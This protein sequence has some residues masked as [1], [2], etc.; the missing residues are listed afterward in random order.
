MSV[1]KSR[2][3]KSPAKFVQLAD[4]IYVEVYNFMMRLSNRQQRL[5]AP[6]TTRLALKALDEAE[7]GNSIMVKDENTYNVRTTHLLE[8]LAAMNAVDV[9]MTHIWKILMQN[10]QG[11]FTKSDGSTKSPSEAIVILDDMANSLGEKIDMFY[12]YVNKLIENEREKYQY[13]VND[14]ANKNKTF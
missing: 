14:S 13:Y 9:N 1:L 10:P 12:N 7:M 4:E 11:A 8:A 2:R 3:H 5:L 6:E